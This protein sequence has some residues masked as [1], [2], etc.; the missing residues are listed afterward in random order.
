[1]LQQGR[2]GLTQQNVIFR[3]DDPAR[4]AVQQRGIIG[5]RQS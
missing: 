4:P 3:H 2:E 5:G 1:V